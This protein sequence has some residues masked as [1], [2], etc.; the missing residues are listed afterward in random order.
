MA[1]NELSPWIGVLTSLIAL[2]FVLGLAW[3]MLRW[4]KRTPWG[5]QAAGDDSGPQ[6]LRAVSLGP[7]ERLVV[8]RH[9]D[10][11]LL[12]GV[13]AA[14]ITLIERRIIDK[15]ADADTDAAA[16]PP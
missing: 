11:E 3:L 7:R 8:V 16:P 2:V 12:L 13:T 1:A 9:H 6:V 15:A 5:R 10:A 4:L 14:G